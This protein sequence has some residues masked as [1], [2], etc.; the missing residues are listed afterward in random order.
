MKKSMLLLPLLLTT[1]IFASDGAK[2]FQNK[3]AMCH[4]TLS[5]A[6]FKKSKEHFA[7]SMMDIAN[8]LNKNIIVEEEDIHRFTMIAFI[9]EYTKN[10]N[11]DYSIYDVSGVNIYSLM[12]PIQMSENDRQLVAEYVVD[13]FSGKKFSN[14]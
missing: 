11:W 8:K 14:K 6:E 13:T 7:P 2:I 1:S 5:E 4:S 3:C 10:P 9:K 12:P